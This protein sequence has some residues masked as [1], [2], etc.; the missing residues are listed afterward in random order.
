VRSGQLDG[1]N[2]VELA[3][4]HRD[5]PGVHRMALAE[6]DKVRVFNRV[7]VNGHFASNGDVLDVLDVSVQGMTAR[8]EDGREAFVAWD[9]LHGPL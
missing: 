9:K 1:P 2:R 4:P 7:W 8:N 3:V 6:G 5:D